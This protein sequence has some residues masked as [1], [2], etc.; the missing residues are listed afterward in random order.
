MSTLTVRNAFVL[1]YYVQKNRKTKKFHPAVWQIISKKQFS[2]KKLFYFIQAYE[3]TRLFC[4]H[5]CQGVWC[6]NKKKGRQF[7]L[8]A[9]NMAG[10]SWLTLTIWFRACFLLCWKILS[11]ETMRRKSSKEEWQKKGNMLLLQYF[12]SSTIFFHQWKLNF[13]GYKLND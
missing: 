5:H 4:T 2:Q 9:M 12:H 10:Q 8:L 3:R 6:C 7:E 1:I 13:P 11:T